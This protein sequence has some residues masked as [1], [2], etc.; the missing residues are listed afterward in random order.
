MV[1][2]EGK[3][4]VREVEEEGVRGGEKGVVREREDVNKLFN[5]LL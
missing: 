4:V 3:G 5:A 2:E 1:R